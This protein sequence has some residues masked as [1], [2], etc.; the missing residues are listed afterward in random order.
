MGSYES[1][2][3][4]IDEP[5]EVW[6]QI[7]GALPPLGGYS[8]QILLPQEDTGAKAVSL[9][10]W[11]QVCIKY[12]ASMTKQQRVCK[13]KWA[14]KWFGQNVTYDVS[15]FLG[16]GMPTPVALS[17]SEPTGDHVEY[18][19]P[20]QPALALLVLASIGLK[21]LHG[22]CRSAG[23]AAKEPLLTA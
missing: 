1:V 7:P 21:K 5:V 3:N 14:P 16:K 12:N 9:S 17:A 4:D 18:F 15:D 2:F 20:G 11:H 19:F 22:F 6:W 23:T 13:Y 8:D 10:L